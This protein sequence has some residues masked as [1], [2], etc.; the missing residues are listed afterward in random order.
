M[1]KRTCLQ[2]FFSLLM[3]ACAASL[4]MGYSEMNGMRVMRNIPVRNFS[5]NWYSGAPRLT[6]ALLMIIFPAFFIGITFLCKVGARFCFALVTGCPLPRRVISPGCFFKY[7]VHQAPLEWWRF[8]PLA[9]SLQNDA[10]LPASCP[11]QHI[12]HQPWAVY[13]PFHWLPVSGCRRKRSI[14][15]CCQ[16]QLLLR[17]RSRHV[18]RKERTRSDARSSEQQ[19]RP[20][21]LQLYGSRRRDP[22]ISSTGDLI[23]CTDIL[24]S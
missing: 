16:I 10:F 24:S 21:I 20:I 18:R 8:L 19:R 4:N 17:Q 1:P 7:P 6:M 3:R 13:P 12:N 23:R 5:T 14:S 11:I 22:V 9:V 15:G 2:K